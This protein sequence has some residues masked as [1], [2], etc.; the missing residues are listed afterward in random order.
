[1]MFDGAALVANELIDSI[2]L[3]N[4][5]DILQKV[6][7]NSYQYAATRIDNYPENQREIVFIDEAIL[8]VG[9][10]RFT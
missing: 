7:D 4:A 2:Q 8:D 6:V 1:M 5:N 10:F 9:I 3:D